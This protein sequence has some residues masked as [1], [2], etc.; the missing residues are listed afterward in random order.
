MGFYKNNAIVQNIR[1][2]YNWIEEKTV[3]KGNN[4]LTLTNDYVSGELLIFDKKYGVRWDE[5][6]HW[7]ISGKIITFTSEMQEDLTFEI[8]NLS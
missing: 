7:T 5:G 2:Q 6:V 8:I 4:T 3:T 1:I